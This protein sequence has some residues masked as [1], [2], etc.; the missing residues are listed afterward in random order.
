M[1]LLVTLALAGAGLIFYSIESD[2]VE[3]QTLGEIDQELTELERLQENGLNPDTRE[4]FQ[5]VEAM[6]MLFLARNVPNDDE[7]LVGWW[8]GRPQVSSPADDLAESPTF[9]AAVQPLV[10]DSGSIRLHDQADGELLDR[11][12]V[13]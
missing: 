3:E 12:S 5:S 7:L 4:P 13:V 1:A 6:L 11:K 8:R 10:R 2:R 9:Q